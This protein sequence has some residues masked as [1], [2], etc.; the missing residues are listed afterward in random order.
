MR[1]RQQ[2][3]EN[4]K[5]LI[6]QRA[7]SF[8]RTTGLDLKDLI[9][10]G[11]LCFCR[12]QRGY[13][14]KSG[15]QFSTYLYACLN[16]GLIDFAKQQNKH[17]KDTVY[18]EDKEL[19]DKYLACNKTMHENNFFHLLSSLSKEA[20]YVT[21]IIFDSPKELLTLYNIK[22]PNIKKLYK[23]LRT[24]GWNWKTITAVFTE[25]KNLVQE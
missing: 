13:R 11:N 10:E 19:Q 2:N 15:T 21:E 12:A 22:K 3:Y 18:L 7:W 20:Y 25:L 9:A 4:Y 23:H 1:Y 5:K 24:L 6:M 8:H 14:P 16:K 17:T